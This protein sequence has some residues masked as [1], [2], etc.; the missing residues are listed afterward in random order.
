MPPL[1]C[2]NLP[3]VC[4]HGAGEGALLVA[5]QLALEQVLRDRRAV[6]RDERLRGARA[7]RVHRLGQQFL[8]RAAL[9]EQQHARIGGGDLLDRA[10]GFRHRVA[11]RDDP[12]ERH[13][14]LVLQQGPVLLLER[15]DVEGAL[16]QQA[17]HVGVDRLLVEIVGA[18]ADGPH[19][20]LLVELP[21]HDDDLGVGRELERLEQAG[22]PLG[23]PFGVRGKTQVLQ[24]DGGLVTTQRRD[25]GGA[26]RHGDHFVIA[27]APLE[28]LLQS[29]VVLDDQQLRFVFGHASSPV[30]KIIQ[31]GGAH[32]QGAGHAS[33]GPASG[34]RN[35]TRVPCPRTLATSTR[36]P[37]DLTYSRTW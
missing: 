12:V 11:D 24:H 21:G 22:E 20:V 29:R 2:S 7:Q 19:R 9:A 14:A 32:D 35:V 34:I 36:P 5:E 1:A 23:D 13:L 31:P 37:S 6:D 18:Q 26:I 4:L 15:V 10:A 27:E 28:L 30:P 17:Q 33:G 3:W 8:A 25:R 16:H